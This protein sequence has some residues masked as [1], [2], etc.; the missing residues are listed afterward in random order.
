MNDDANLKRPG[1]LTALAII[2]FVLGGL[3]T[4]GVIS[5]LVMGINGEAILAAMEKALEQANDPNREQS[6]KPLRALVEATSDPIKLTIAV[7]LSIAVAGLLIVSGLGYLKQQRFRGRTL[8]NA[9]AIIALASLGYT[10]SMMGM[11][12]GI[13]NLLDVIYP[14]VT[15]CMVN[16]T[17]KDDLV[18]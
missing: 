5:I 8:G 12:F 4:I 9:Y 17:F 7:L 16:L 11:Q 3:A 10:M 2:N 13:M 1:G 18:K 14:V 15:L 6:L